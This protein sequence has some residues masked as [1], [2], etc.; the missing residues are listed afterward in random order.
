MIDSDVYF[1]LPYL[2]LNVRRIVVKFTGSW[3]YNSDFY[4]AYPMIESITALDENG[5]ELPFISP[6]S[7]KKLS[8]Q[9]YLDLEETLQDKLYDDMKAVIRDDFGG[10]VPYERSGRRLKEVPT[11]TAEFDIDP[12]EV[13]AYMEEKEKKM[14]ELTKR[15]DEI[16]QRLET[17]SEEERQDELRKLADELVK[18][19][20]RKA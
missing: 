5:E 9:K 19:V 12:E 16:L 20:Y 2:P 6:K 8:K 3:E 4:V 11:Y 7:G 13:I 10:I 15:K 18:L 17:M 1:L 14:D